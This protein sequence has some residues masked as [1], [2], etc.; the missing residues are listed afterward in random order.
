MRILLNRSQL[1][2]VLIE[3]TGNKTPQEQLDEFNEQEDK[4]KSLSIGREKARKWVNKL[5]MKYPSLS[6]RLQIGNDT[7]IAR[8]EIK[9]M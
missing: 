4:V 2:R 3:Q 9:R 1:N 6:F 8:S 5:E 7:L